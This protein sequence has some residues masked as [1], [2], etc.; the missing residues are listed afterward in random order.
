M[1]QRLTAALRVECAN[2]VGCALPPLQ[3]IGHNVATLTAR[4]EEL[5]EGRIDSLRYIRLKEFFL[6][7]RDANAINFQVAKKINNSKW[8]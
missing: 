5:T 1:F 2:L 6:K 7:H 8:L 3:S 4:T